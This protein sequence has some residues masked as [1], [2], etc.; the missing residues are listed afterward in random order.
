M[1]KIYRGGHYEPTVPKKKQQNNTNAQS[2][3]SPVLVLNPEE[4]ASLEAVELQE[5]QGNAHVASGIVPEAELINPVSQSPW[6]TSLFS[7]GSEA[8]QGVDW[9][10]NT[11]SQYTLDGE[12]RTEHT[13]D[14]YALPDEKILY[15]DSN[16]R[17]TME[18]VTDVEYY[19]GSTATLGREGVR[20]GT[21]SVEVDGTLIQEERQLLNRIDGT[22]NH[23]A[24]GVSGGGT[25]QL[26]YSDK[27]TVISGDLSDSNQSR[28][29]QRS[30][31]LEG[32]VSVIKDQNSQQ[33][34]PALR[35]DTQGPQS[36]ALKKR[37]IL[38]SEVQRHRVRSFRSKIPR[39]ISSLWL[40]MIWPVASATHGST[41]KASM[42]SRTR[43]TPRQP[44]SANHI[45]RRCRF[46]RP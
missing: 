36:S 14:P 18:N 7:A 46:N 4:L 13:H 25:G 6:G 20:E 12:V 23:D 27:T 15:Q 3:Q 33:I 21:R 31:R 30:R 32:E 24:S 45:C 5:I 43:S 9:T 35:G 17:F 44:W 2:N 8:I 22:I 38:L 42:W 40:A 41:S 10:T 1:N 19:S 34:L 16:T 26:G 11:G 28:A 29:E 37:S 39:A